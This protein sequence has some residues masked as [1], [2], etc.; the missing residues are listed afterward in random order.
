MHCKRRGPRWDPG[1]GRSHTPQGNE[2]QVPQLLS[3]RSRLRE[4]QLL[5][6]SAATTEAHAPIA[7]ALQQE[8]TTVR[9]PPPQ[10]SSS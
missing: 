8:A 10:G 9:K 1:P 3:L 6:P 7:C 4:P 5:R 2:A